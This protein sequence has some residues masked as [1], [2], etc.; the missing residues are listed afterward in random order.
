MSISFEKLSSLLFEKGYNKSYL[1]ERGIHPAIISK[2][3]KGTLNRENR[4]DT[5]TINKLCEILYCQPGD[6]MEYI[7]DES[8]KNSAYLDMI[9]RSMKQLEAGEGTA[10][11]LIEV[12]DD[13]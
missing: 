9:D 12:D 8:A 7:P 6:L 1:R 5:I 4:V 11:E 3:S 13:H 2:L 10:H